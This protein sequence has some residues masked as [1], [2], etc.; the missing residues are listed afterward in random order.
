[1][2]SR[3]HGGV[4]FIDLFD[5]QGLVQIV[6]NPDMSDFKAIESMSTHSVMC[7]EGL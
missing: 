1:M 6:A 4:I 7:I 3:D 5:H 2:R